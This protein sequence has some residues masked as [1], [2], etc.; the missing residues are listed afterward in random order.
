[1]R[2]ESRRHLEEGAPCQQAVSR[3]SEHDRLSF[4]ANGDRRSSVFARNLA[5]RSAAIVFAVGAVLLVG[6]TAA[7][8][9][10][11]PPRLVL[12]GK[13]GERA[14]NARGAS[15]LYLTTGSPLVCQQGE[16]LPS[17]VSAIR[18][19]VWGFFGT[20]VHV[21]AYDGSRL[22]TE[23]RRGAAWTSDSVTVP[24]KPIAHTTSGVT[25]CFALGPNSEPIDILGPRTSRRLAAAIWRTNPSTAGEATPPGLLRG[26][27]AVEY[28]AA[29]SGSWWSRILAT[30]RHLGLGRA[31]SGTWI[32]LVVAALMAAT[33][34]LAV[35]LTLRELSRQSEDAI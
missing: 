8:L 13:P 1:M 29:G 4:G 31:F 5:V 16:V 10:Q 22:L 27:V 3:L 21:T 14:I 6:I 33:C 2:T 26:R 17:H 23:G 24:V 28:L 18:L 12:I 30:A 35:G 9:S 34:A 32:A 19:S 25:L 11:A 7:V 15:A 20:P